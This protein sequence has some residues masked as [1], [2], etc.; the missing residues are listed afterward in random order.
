MADSV[1]VFLPL[2]IA[3]ATGVGKTAVALEVARELGG[4]II[5]ADSMQVYR[6][7]D[8]GTAK[9]TAKE[10][11]EIPHHLIDI[12]NLT[13]GFDAAA[14]V[15]EAGKAMLEI[16]GRGR[17]PVFCGGTGLYLKAWLEGL[18][19][20][21]ASNPILRAELESLGIS[22]LL[23]ELERLDPKTYKNIDRQNKRRLVRA[24]EVIRLSGKPFS[25]QRAGWGGEVRP[26]LG[27]G[28]ERESVDLHS[29]IE[30]RVEAMFESGLVAEARQFLPQFRQNRTASQAIGYR[31]LLDYFEGKTD[32]KATVEAVKIKTRQFSK[33]QR[34]WFKRQMQLEWISI[35]REGNLTEI[36]REIARSYRK[37]IEGRWNA[38]NGS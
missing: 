17:V 28:L 7:L 33:R 3:G 18:G 9:A 26:V 34:T 23:A 6:G 2:V 24:V 5:S 13:E 31:Q 38:S 4:E 22:D 14:F 12:R 15:S 11:A 8:I 29:R 19:E 30:R 25:E 32:L 1:K 16:T 21:P 10:R 20:A 27:F 35:G 36:A 37:W